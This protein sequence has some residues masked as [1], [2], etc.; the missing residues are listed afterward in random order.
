MTMVPIMTAL[1]AANGEE[2]AAKSIT[3]RFK[4]AGAIEPGHAIAFSPEGATHR[5]EFAMLVKRGALVE[6]RPGTWY[7]NEEKLSSPG[8]AQGFLVV[9]ALA[10]VAVLAAFLLLRAG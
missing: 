9:A 8:M 5:A 1:A 4:E 3:A 10:C 6:M 7:L 2:A